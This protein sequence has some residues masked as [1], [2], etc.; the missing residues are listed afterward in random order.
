MQ[1][2][3]PYAFI[4]SFLLLLTGDKTITAISFI[5]VFI[6]QHSQNRDTK[7][8]HKKLDELIHSSNARNEVA[9]IESKSL[10]EIEG[11]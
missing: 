4:A 1:T 3:S 5:M 8:I 11:L 6:I 2:G 10:D 9:G 7:A